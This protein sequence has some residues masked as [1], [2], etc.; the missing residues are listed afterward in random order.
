VTLTD[1]PVTFAFLTASTLG[2]VFP[3]VSGD[4]SNDF[5]AGDPLGTVSLTA[6][7]H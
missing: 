6:H 7:V 3:N 5:A 2:L 1:V 4:P